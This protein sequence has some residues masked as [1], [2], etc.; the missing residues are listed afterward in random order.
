MAV[1]NEP[2]VA[3]PLKLDRTAFPDTDSLFVLHLTKLHNNDETDSIVPSIPFNIPKLHDA[4][5]RTRTCGPTYMMQQTVYAQM[6]QKSNRQY[7]LCKMYD[8]TDLV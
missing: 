5:D 8:A 7:I 1:V 3:E 4:T 6:V 2:S